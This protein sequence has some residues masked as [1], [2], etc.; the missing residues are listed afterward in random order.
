MPHEQLARMDVAQLNML[1]AEGLPGCEQVGISN[2]LSL[3]DNWAARVKSETTRHAYRFERSPA[4][5]E[6]SRGFYKLLM[7]GV[8]LAEDYR[9]HYRTDRQVSPNLA[10]MNDGF[11]AD[12]R[13]VFLPGLLGESRAGTCSSMPVLYVAIGRRLGYPLKLV[14]T[15]GHLF[16]RWDGEAERF[17]L[18][19]TGN[20]LNRF[21]D[22][23]YRHW[24]FEVSNGEVAAEGYLKSLTPAEELA[25]F[26]SIR[27]MCLR[28]T[29]RVNEAADAFAA[30]AKLAPNV[31]SYQMMEAHCRSAISSQTIKQ[32]GKASL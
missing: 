8:V 13:D 2:T 29:S 1:C 15:K 26:L 12:A 17:N 21:S 18:E 19:V 30:A 20:G 32:N 31:Q 16:V 9:V 5:F 14:T 22:D 28:E 25:V 6:N 7:L 24:P 4:E 23:Y 27:A 3:L 10:T 11:F